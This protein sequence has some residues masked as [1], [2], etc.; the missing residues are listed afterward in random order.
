LRGKPDRADPDRRPPRRRLTPV[1]HRAS[2]QARELAHD[3][4][5]GIGT[6]SL[7]TGSLELHLGR[8]LSPAAA[9]DLAGIRAGLERMSTLISGALEPSAGARPAAG[10]RPVD[11]NAVLD[12]ARANIEASAIRARARIVAEPLPWALGDA[13]ELTRLF[14]NLLAN[15]IEHRHPERP[16]SVRIGA[17]RQGYG[18]LFEVADNGVGIEPGVAARVLDPAG[19]EPEAGP[20]PGLGLRIC[21]RIVAAHGGRIRALPR[22]EGGTT[23]SFGL[24]AAQRAAGSRRSG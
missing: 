24:P 6:I 5:E 23:V 2:E 20:D 15:A 9:R 1:D 14:Q 4:S 13:A 12:A 22:A 21:A 19:G 7:F 18:W 3:L 8:D 17:R 10:Q 16:P 11:M